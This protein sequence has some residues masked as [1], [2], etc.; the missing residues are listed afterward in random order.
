MSRT[1]K[2][3]VS[4]EGVTVSIDAKNVTA[5]GAKGELSVTIL[6]MVEVE[7][8]ENTLVFSPANDTKKAQA[9]WGTSRALVQNIVTGVKEGFQKKLLISGVGY[10]A[11]M[12][13]N[14]LKLT[15]GF[16]HDVV[17]QPPQGIEIK[18]PQ[19]TEIVVS[20]ADKQQVGQVAANIRQYR[21]PEPYKGKGVRY[22]DEY[23]F[24]KEGKK[25]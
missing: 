11:A 2:L 24:R 18:T 4:T 14:N 21:K 1:G 17:Y 25:K 5:K 23:I 13:G 20:G 10:R 6:D 7:Q 19:P 9:N 8:G 15:L 22:E 3:P 16:S 12:Q